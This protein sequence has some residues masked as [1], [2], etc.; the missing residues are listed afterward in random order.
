[1][2]PTERTGYW[3]TS[4]ALVSL[5][6]PSL[7]AVA[8]QG[9]A[10]P[11]RGA[12]VLGAPDDAELLTAYRGDLSNQRSQSWREYR[13]WVRTFYEGNLMSEGWSRFG[14]VTVS[15]VKPPE[16]RRA[17]VTQVN[18]LGRI[19]GL[20]WAKDSGVRRISTTD[21][22][23]WNAVIAA[24]RRSDDGSGRR[25]IDALRAVRG[26]VEGRHRCD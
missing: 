19:I 23:R 6:L 5:W 15:A 20:E 10:A 9:T 18:E 24:A 11:A 2:I 12:T 21:L 8:G 7:D 16:A 14:E 17:V 3:A 13:G 26:M 4:V 1:M 22:K 25:T